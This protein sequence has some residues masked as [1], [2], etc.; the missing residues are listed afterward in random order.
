MLL[1][2][3]HIVTTSQA[4]PFAA[5]ELTYRYSSVFYYSCIA[6][7]KSKSDKNIAINTVFKY[8]WIMPCWVWIVQNLH[9]SYSLALT[10]Q[11][12][13]VSIFENTW[14]DMARSCFHWRCKSLNFDRCNYMVQVLI[15]LST[16]TVCLIPTGCVP[17]YLLMWCTPG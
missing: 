10:W 8:Q 1:F 15:V 17:P 9:M 4:G 12:L 14:I 3:I 7:L 6:S 16:V 5:G 2:L 13:F 11:L